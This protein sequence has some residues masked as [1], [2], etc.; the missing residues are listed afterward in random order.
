MQGSVLGPLLFL[1][2]ISP[3]RRIIEDHGIKRHSYADDTQLYCAILVKPKSPELLSQQLQRMESTD[4]PLGRPDKCRGP[5]AHIRASRSP[6]KKKEKK[7][8]RFW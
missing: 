3:L 7:K 1:I 2:Y 4:Y 8:R 5:R 6:K